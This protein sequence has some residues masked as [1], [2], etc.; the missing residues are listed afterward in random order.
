MIEAR[1]WT[2][3]SLSLRAGL[4][5]EAVRHILAG[6]S[7]HPRHDTVEKLAAALDVDVSDLLDAA[8]QPGA[9][10]PPPPGW[11]SAAD[12]RDAMDRRQPRRGRRVEPDLVPLD[13]VR[14][15]GLVGARDLPVY[16]SAE[17]GPSG[18]LVT[19][20][21]IEY[22]RRPEPLMRVAGGFGVYVVG[23]SMAPAYEHGDRILVHPSK[24]PRRGDD[25][26]L[27]KQIDGHAAGLVKRLLSWN[28]EDWRLRQYNPPEDFTL[29]RHEWTQALVIVGRYNRS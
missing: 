20:E 3:R 12:E 28:G 11:T 7:Q 17:G 13:D 6:R 19:W 25:V 21:P 22:V 23:D 8:A 16:A 24:F 9:A 1:G 14:T 26:F 5:A 4:S 27:V 29:P 10:T 18:M 15:D 2:P